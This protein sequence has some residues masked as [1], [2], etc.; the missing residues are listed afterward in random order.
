MIDVKRREDCCGCNACGDICPKGAISYRVDEEG[1][2]YPAVDRALCVDCGLCERAC[3]CLHSAE[4]K[5]N[6][7]PESVCY[8]AEHK[9]LE[10]VFDSTSGGMFSALAEAMYRA[11]G[12]VGGAVFNEDLSVSQFISADKKD[13]PRLRSSK[14]LQSR[15]DGFYREIKRLLVAGEKVLVCGTPCQMAGLRAF[16]GRDYE[17]LII[18]DF[19]CLGINSPKLWQSYL[20]SFEERYG[21]RVVYA[22][23]KSK[24]Y[25]WRNLTQKVRLADGREVFETKD[26]SKY[27]QGFIGTHTYCR[28]SCYECRFKGLPRM[29]DIT[30]ADFWGIERYEQ[31]LE[32]NLGTSLVML[33]SQKGVDY[34]ETIK[35]DINT[36]PMPFETIFAG[37]RA[38]TTP[39][40]RPT[41]DRA[42]FF[43][44]AERMT[45]DELAEKYI[46]HPPKT[47][48]RRLKDTVKR[49]L[50]IARK[51]KHVLSVTRCH[52]RALY[53][54]VRYSGINNLLHGRG[55]LFSTHCTVEI[56]RDARLVFHGLLTFGAKGRF[57]T[58]TL[59]SRLLVASGATLEVL[60]NIELGYGAEVEVFSG[61][62]LTLHGRKLLTSY[63][64]IGCTIICG[65]HI[66]LGPDVVI[67]RDVTI[68]DNNGGHYLNKA[69]YQNTHPVIIGEKAW[70]CENCIIMPGAQVGASA[71]VGARAVVLRQSAVPSH[72]LVVGAP[73]RVVAEGIQ[74]KC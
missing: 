14:Y 68:R 42:A 54:T 1:F 21:S 70:L 57:P 53:Q 69:G 2:W 6:D 20:K 25:G 10:V 7:L 47:P 37:N 36:I 22:K 23:A 51:V 39:C 3:P 74:W 9:N 60:G 50:S 67:G 72:S 15:A 44:D 73:A 34:F 31:R 4:L 58:S 8:A 30:L 62:R 66:E 32:K 16:L 63:A 43:A 38:L 5:K 11:H 61:A 49:G 64:N 40:A 12:F 13:L 33:N 55:I 27:M 65:E 18:V 59:E 46:L 45:F 26:V 17:E 24:E 19:I 48:L 52:P 29:A 56:A 71:V 41:I 35:P 28:P